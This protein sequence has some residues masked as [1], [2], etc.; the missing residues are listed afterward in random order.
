VFTVTSR[1]QGIPTATYQ[2]PDGRMVVYVRRWFL[3]H[4]EDLAQIGEHVVQAGERY[5]LDLIAAKEIDNAELAW[6]IADANRA[7][8]PDDLTTP[9]GRRLRV[10][11]PAGIPRGGG[12]LGAPHG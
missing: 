2:L 5:R 6:Q 9:P 12:L 10:T 1:Y 8:D 4:P 11:L 7:M 3:P